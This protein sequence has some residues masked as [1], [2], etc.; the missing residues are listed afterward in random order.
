MGMVVAEKGAEVGA[1]MV[2]VKEVVIG[3]VKVAVDGGE[4]VAMVGRVVV[5]VGLLP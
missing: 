5:M 3:A 2:V 4:V 1:G